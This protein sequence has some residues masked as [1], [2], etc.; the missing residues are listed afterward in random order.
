MRILHTADWHIGQRL[1]EHPRHDEHESFLNWLLQTIQNHNVELLLVAG[2][3]FDTSL[4]SAE[5][6]NLYYEF[7]FRLYNE[8]DTYTIIIAGNH[9][10]ARHLEAPREFLKMGRIHVVGHADEPSKCVVQI[11]FNDQPRVSVGAVPYLLESELP[12][13]SYESEIDKSE[14]YRERLRTFYANCVSHM[15]ADI[16][17]ILMG[18]LF[19]Q[20][21]QPTDS[22][23]NIQFGGA[24]AIHVDDFP[25]DVDYVALGHLHRP[26]SIKGKAYPIRY[27]G[28]PIPMRFNEAN[29]SKKVFLL[30]L[31]EDGTFVADEEILIP[32]SKVLCTVEGD[33]ASVMNRAM[34]G[35]WEG[36]YI[37]V[38]L[39]LM[40]METG[41]NDRIRQAFAD[42][43]GEVL[44]VEIDL[45]D[46]KRDLNIT[47]EDM[48][49]PKEIFEQYYKANHDGNEPDDDLVQTFTELLE[50]V[51]KSQ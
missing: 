31:S 10:S 35:D 19:V 46:V 49:Q 45:Q 13:L 25:D 12:H 27:S 16:P 14:R 21:G 34:A 5:A 28:S 6:T 26:Q 20:G 15:P 39:N 2:D 8:T 30:E 50:I 9:D 40:A 23:R 43:G 18:H 33:E 29:Y 22:E 7:L 4:P 17:K 47:V 51:E 36:K 1:H 37:Q 48:K 38:K 3:I 11:P 24:T 41:I 44:S 32:C 42:R